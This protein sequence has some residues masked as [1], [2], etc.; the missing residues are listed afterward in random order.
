MKIDINKDFEKAFPDDLWKGFT[1]KQIIT[2][3]VG[4]IMAAGTII[5]L[6]VLILT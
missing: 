2:F 4:L 1:L 3:S 5:A 6:W